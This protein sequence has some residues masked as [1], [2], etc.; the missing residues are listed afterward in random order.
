MARKILRVMLTLL[1]FIAVAD[2]ANGQYT[3][4]NRI[5]AETEDG[6]QFTAWTEHSTVIL[7]QNIVI[8][9]Q[10]KNRGS[11]VIYL[12]TED[13]PEIAIEDDATI[14]IEAPY[15]SPSNPT[16][17]DYSFT[18]IAPE[19]SYQGQFTI[20][21]QQYRR[22]NIWPIRIGF[23]YVFD[24]SLFELRGSPR[25]SD[26]E[27][28]NLLYSRIQVVGAGELTVNVIK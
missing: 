23:G 17:F 25:V 3:K 11:K 24:I 9:F 26:T 7:G 21:K 14:L 10:V 27:L 6:V 18:K 15:S 4:V 28:G 19:K 12:V 20:T 22:D 2:Q 1:I 13:V 16:E 8:K 5:C